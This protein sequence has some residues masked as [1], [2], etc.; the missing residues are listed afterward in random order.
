VTTYQ[1][2]AAVT[3]T[4]RYLVSS[5]IRT[6]VPEARVTLRRPEEPAAAAADEPRV[7]IY[8]VQISPEATMRSNDLPTRDDRGNL[9]A[10]P[11]APV[12]LRYLLSFFGVS[13]KAHLMLGATEIALR[14][15]A[16]LDPTLIRQ[17]LANH[18]DLHGSGL[19]Q[20]VPAVRIVP[21]SVTL[22][23]LSRFWSGFLQ[24]PYTVS[25]VYDATTVILTS[26]LEP[27]ATLPVR[28]VGGAR[29]GLPP[30]LDPPATVQFSS[31]RGGTVVPVS[32]RGVALGQQVA[33]AAEWAPLEPAPGGGLQFRL[34]A[35]A[36]AGS[37]PIQLGAI[38]EG[39]L[40]PEPIA[41]SRPQTLTVR[42]LL[43]GVRVDRGGISA[44]VTV[45]PVAHAGQQAVLSLVATDASTQPD[46]PDPPSAQISTTVAITGTQLRFEIPPRLPDGE[47]LAV[48]D[49]DGV[50]SL[51]TVVA[52]RYA[53]PAVELSR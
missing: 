32:G 30:Q 22:E 28:R 42:P 13:E 23:E 46:A 29:G 20:Q 12:N 51:P 45:S 19:E 14:A 44:T 24:T 16:V 11:Q 4:L 1:G 33:V 3:Q 25:T 31:A 9:L 49:L 52:G 17:A 37:Q 39:G 8:L 2:I 10:A 35:G 41:G 48:I 6:A 5:A 18:P 38:P 21:S 53:R 43:R 7:N 36:R 40:E 26:E 50:S 34:P 47:Y 15:R 27:S